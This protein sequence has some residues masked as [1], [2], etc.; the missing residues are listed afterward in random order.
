MNRFKFND[1]NEPRFDG[2][3]S[4]ECRRTSLAPARAIV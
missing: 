4:E 1:T 3:E 2:Y